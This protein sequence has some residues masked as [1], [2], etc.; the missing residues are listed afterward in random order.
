[1]AEKRV[2][3]LIT[4]KKDIDFLLSLKEEDISFSLM[5]E[6]FGEFNG[7]QRFHP[8]DILEV[9]PNSY[10]PENDR[11]T[12]KFVTTVGLWVWNIYHL[13]KELHHILGYINHTIDKK[14][15]G[16]IDS[17]LSYALLE[18]DITI[19]HIKNFIHKTQADMPFVS[20]V[21]PS[22]TEKMLTSTKVIKKKKEELAKKYKKEIEAGDEVAI[23]RMEKELLDYAKDYLDGDP[24]L[25]SFDSGARGSFGN[26]FKNMF[27][28]KGAI[29]DPDPN[30]GYNIAMSNYMDGVSKEEYAVFANSLAAG[31]YARGKKTEIGGYWEKLFVAAFQH[32]VLDP[33]GSDCKT[34]KYVTV[35]LDNPGDW[36]Y[37]YMIEGNNLVELNSKNVDK[38]KGKTVKFRFSSMC[39]S[40]TGIC[41]KCAGNMFYKLGIKNIGM[42]LPVIP[43]TLKNL[44]MKSFH[45]SSVKTTEMDVMKAFGLK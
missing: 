43:S 34:D 8:Y 25:D 26:N 32:V 36:M 22:M 35:K 1:M 2:A 19:Q 42:T 10:G 30:K 6:M 45:D 23:E 17:T 44:S 21:S 14:A 7:K 31:P 4:D 11:N 28:I 38:Y 18:D 3:K 16:K 41:N 37:S 12:N 13:E 39:K 9:P 20:I 40:K 29:K 5:M 15:F 33:E 24:S 27:I